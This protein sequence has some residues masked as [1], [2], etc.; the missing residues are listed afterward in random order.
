MD[1]FGTLFARHHDI[2]RMIA[3]QQEERPEAE[4]YSVGVGIHYGEVFCGVIGN[5]GRREFTVIG[6]P[7]NVAAR[8]EA[9]TR[10]T[11][12]CLLA[13]EAVVKAADAEDRWSVF[14]REQLRGRDMHTTLMVPKSEAD[15]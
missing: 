9:A 7:V 12:V 15:I 2:V 3:E 11:N 14:S 5:E 4:R 6:D 13:S 10:P 1:D 8:I